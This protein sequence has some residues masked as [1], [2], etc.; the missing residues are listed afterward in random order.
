LSA[1]QLTL[2]SLWCIRP[3]QHFQQFNSLFEQ[4]AKNTDEDDDNMKL[5]GPIL[6]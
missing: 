2:L 5:V 4:S 1:L 6:L 3:L